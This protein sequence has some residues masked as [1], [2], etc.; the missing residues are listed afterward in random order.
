[1]RSKGSDWVETRERQLHHLYPLGNPANR[2]HP[3]SVPEFRQARFSH[4]VLQFVLW[5]CLA[6]SLPLLWRTSN[7]QPSAL[8]W[9][10]EDVS[11]VISPALFCPHKLQLRLPCQL[12][13]IVFNKWCLSAAVGYLLPQRWQFGEAARR[14][15]T[16]HIN[17]IVRSAWSVNTMPETNTSPQGG[18]RSTANV[19]TSLYFILFYFS[20]QPNI[21]FSKTNKLSFAYRSFPCS[22]TPGF[23]QERISME[24]TGA[25]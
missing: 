15:R 9:K 17:E 6:E 10:K 5:N 21:I 19:M 25:L 16:A 22:L 13:A 24:Q 20:L 1:M 12:T 4:V 11:L 14:R 18:H 2:S 7:T 3:T 23:H 8:F